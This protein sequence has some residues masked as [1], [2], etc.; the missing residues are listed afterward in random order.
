MIDRDGDGRRFFDCHTHLFPPQRLGGLMRWIRRAIPDYAVPEDITAADA[1]RDLRAA[2]AVRWANL[3]FPI[4]GGEAAHLHAWGSELAERVPEITPFGGVHV[5][6]D[7]PLGVVQEAIE[8]YK[9]AGLKFHPMVQGFDPWDERLEPV[10]GYLDSEERPIY[11]HTGYEEW[12]GHQMDRAA[13]ESMV[14]THPG[15]PVVL[16][17]L[18][19]PDLDWAFSLAD[20][21][22]NVWLDLTNVPGSFPWLGLDGDHDLLMTFR[23]G[24]SRHRDRSLMGTDYPAG[25]GSLEQII[26]QFESVDFEPG[27]LEYVMT[28]STASFFDRYGRP[29][30]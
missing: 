16:P 5:D 22:Q 18:G 9:M 27:L 13:L 8:G 3:L 2:G 10:L 28:T 17:H 25:M 15:L 30:P 11:V 12:Y 1:V 4:A 14:Q 6:D 20:R 7:D 19:F 26:E 21:Y 24:V 23:A 29:R